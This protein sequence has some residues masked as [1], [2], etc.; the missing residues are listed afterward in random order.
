MDLNVNGGSFIGLTHNHNY[1]D[2]LRAV[3][4]GI[5]FDHVYR[6]EK[7]KENGI[8]Y[9]SAVLTGGASRSSVFCRMFSDCLGIK[10]YTTVN[11][12]TGT[13]GV[14]VLGAVAVG[15]YP[16]IETATQKMVCIKQ[17]YEPRVN[18]ALTLKYKRFKKYLAEFR[19]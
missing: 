3:F 19:Q 1:K 16:D 11:S 2:M 18:S 8:V 7:L 6:I 15:I 10:I 12:Q 14:A 4:E 17:C 13:L 9:D 5:V